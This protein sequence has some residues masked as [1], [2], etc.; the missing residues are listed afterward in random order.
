VPCC[1]S[2]TASS[3]AAALS[4][5]EAEVGRL[6]E[7]QDVFKRM[8]DDKAQEAAQELQAYKAQAADR[9][10]A[11]RGKPHTGCLAARHPQER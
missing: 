5:S 8:A 2:C 6:K 10:A 11:A 7:W 4:K 3:L 9:Q 1:T